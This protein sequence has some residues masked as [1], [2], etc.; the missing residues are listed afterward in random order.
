MSVGVGHLTNPS[1]AKLRYIRQLGIKDIV[2]NGAHDGFVLAETTL[3]EFDKLVKLRNRV[4]NA[5][6]TLAA[7][8]NLPT[9][10]YD[11]IMLGHPGWEAQL[12]NVK[13]TIRNLGRADIPIL[14]YHWS[15][16]G[17]VRTSATR[18]VHGGA[19]AR[20]FDLDSASKLPL[21]FNRE[22]S[23]D[24]LW[25][26]Y[27]RFIK[28]VVPVADE[29]GVKLALHPNDPPVTD[30]LGGVPY[31]F[32]SFESFQRAM[33]IV[34]N[35]HHGLNLG[36]GNWCLMHDDLIEV[37]EHFGADNRIHYVHFRDTIGDR[38]DFTEVFIEHGGFSETTVLEALYNVGFNGVLIPD[39]VP[40]VEGDT[41]WSHRGRGYAAGYLKGMLASLTGA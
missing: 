20:S 39:H 10:H 6:L 9:S 21:Q 24:E 37:I 22:Y 13:E 38:T 5:G 18:R 32:N 35:P 27:E 15:P 16:G 41:D 11:K 2:F 12:E 33:N 34:D 40:N 23:E 7:I 4:E 17:V 3:Y 25:Q 29:A 36:L 8:E 28:Q 1:D 30:S 26:N 19:N 31:I 14:G